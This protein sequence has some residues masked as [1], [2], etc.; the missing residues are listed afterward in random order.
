MSPTVIRYFCAAVVVGVVAWGSEK[1]EWTP[2]FDGRTLDGWRVR[3]RQADA[4]KKY[5]TVEDGAIV[6]DSLDDDQH[7]YVWLITDKEYGDFEL[8]LKVRSYPNSPGNTGVQIRSRYDDQAAWL[9]GP[10]VDIH[11]PAGWRS[12][13]IYDETR[14]VQRWIYPSLRNWE[15]EPSQG[16]AKWRWLKDG[17][18][19]VRIRCQGTTIRS[20]VND[21]P[22]ADFDGAGV[23]DD[24]FHRQRNVG[25]RGFIALQLHRGDRLRVAFKSILLRPL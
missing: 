11:P 19:D 18:N 4:A 21:L 15:I 8:R 2:L 20:W 9:D 14:S 23:L 3:C 5:W 1:V 6:C 13:L 7:D 24:A 22:I 25:L 10:Q 16:P 17:W 12:G